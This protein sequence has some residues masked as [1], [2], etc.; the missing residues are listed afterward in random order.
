MAPSMNKNDSEEEILEAFKVFNKDGNG[1]VSAAERRHVEKQLAFGI[2]MWNYD[3]DSDDSP[4]ADDGKTL[5]YKD[6]VKKHCG[7]GAS[8]GGG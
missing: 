2:R 7:D 8:G 4:I 6:F 3:I 5:R 1:F